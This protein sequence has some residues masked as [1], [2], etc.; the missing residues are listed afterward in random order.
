[1]GGRGHDESRCPLRVSF[2]GLVSFSGA[3]VLSAFWA[4]ASE[5]KPCMS[6]S[7]AAAAPPPAAAAAEDEDEDDEGEAPFGTAVLPVEG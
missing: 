5:A 3:G 2:S 6:G 7:A 4:S 1:M